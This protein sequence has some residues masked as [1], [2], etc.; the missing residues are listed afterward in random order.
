MVWVSASLP[1]E[2]PPGAGLHS[3]GR[4]RFHER[5]VVHLDVANRIVAQGHD[6]AR[7]LKIALA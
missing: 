4:E 1:T 2:L 7:R 6:V 5:V 3:S